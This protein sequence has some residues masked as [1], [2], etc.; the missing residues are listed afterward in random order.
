MYLP[1]YMHMYPPTCLPAYLPTH[2]PAYLPTYLLQARRGESYGYSREYPIGDTGETCSVLAAGHNSKK[3]V[4]VV[5]TARATVN[6]F[7]DM[8]AAKGVPVHG[9]G[10]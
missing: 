3:P 10:G 9:G 7:P 5:S 6:G 8:R 4:L 2:L 1:T